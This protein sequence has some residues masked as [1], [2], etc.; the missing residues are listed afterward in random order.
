MNDQ[1]LLFDARWLRLYERKRWVRGQPIRWVY[2]SRGATKRPE[3]GDAVVMVP[4]VRSEEGVRLLI[5]K[6]YRMPLQGEE[7][8]FPAGL[9]EEGENPESTVAR[10][11]LEETGYRLKRVLER[12]PANL[13]STAGLT[14]ETFRYYFV[15]AEAGAGQR[16]EPAEEIEVLLLDLDGIRDLFQRGVRISGRLWPIGRWFLALG[17]FPDLDDWEM[18]G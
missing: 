3:G 10:E 12:S 16:L 6:E 17:R 14:D 15:E 8:G 1:R 2:C 13:V 9:V 5:T 4:L 18:G 7:Y 11:L